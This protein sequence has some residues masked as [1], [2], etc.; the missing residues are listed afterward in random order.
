MRR[1]VL[2]K[3][4]KTATARWFRHQSPARAAA[5]AFYSLAA[6]TPM[7]IVGVAGANWVFRDEA[8]RLLVGEEIGRVGGPG[9]SEFALVVIESLSRPQ[10]SLLASAF[11]LLAVLVGATA[12][13]GQIHV[14]LNYTW[15]VRPEASR[16]I[17][18]FMRRRFLSLVLVFGFGLAILSAV[19]LRVILGS[20]SHRLAGIGMLPIS[21]DWT[22]AWLPIFAGVF[23][24]F[25]LLNRL[26]PDTKV[27]WGEATLGGGISATLFILGQYVLA[28]YLTRAGLVSVYGA[29]GSLVV[30]LIWV[31][32]SAIVFLWGVEVAY[33]SRLL[34]MG[35]ARLPGDPTKERPADEPEPVA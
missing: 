10:P 9:A 26:V 20:I 29:A 3:L 4:L 8:L 32:Y 19:V 11:A 22:G 35:R 17:A 34:E 5:I 2:W 30:T 24:F 12:V 31:Y 18:R 23:L 25:S 13:Y 7:M 21:E 27:T 16:R 28:L 14:A 33:A 6:L 1:T 15:G